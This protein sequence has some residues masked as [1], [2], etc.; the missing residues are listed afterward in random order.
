[1]LLKRSFQSSSQLNAP[2]NPL[3][4]KSDYSRG[5]QGFTIV[6]IVFSIDEH[7]IVNKASLKI[8]ITSLLIR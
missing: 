6:F 7:T 8:R 5:A 4:K 2:L 1:M 3:H